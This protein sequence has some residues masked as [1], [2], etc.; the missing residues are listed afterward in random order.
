MPWGRVDDQ[1]Y[2]HEKVGELDDDLRKGCIALFWL[3]I[4]WCNDRL[5]DGRVP[6]GIVRTLGADSAEADELVRVGLWERDGRGYRVHDFLDFNKSR[7]QVEADRIQ[8]TEAGRLGAKARW[9]GGAPSVSSSGSASDSS[10]EPTDEP[11]GGS[12][13]PVP[14]IPY[15]VTP[16]P[17]A[18]ARDGLTNIDDEATTFLEGVTGRSLRTAGEKQLAEFDRQIG[19]HGLARV[20]A[21]YQRIAKSLPS[22]P[23]PTARQ[24]VWGGMKVLEP[25][26]D[27]KVQEA[28]EREEDTASAWRSRVARTKV[29]THDNGLHADSPDAG[30]P[31]CGAAA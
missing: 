11:D 13:A 28:V 19:D 3:A 1:H 5:T 6:A 30:C 21:A 4:S 14:R 7:A 16:V 9:S 17:A 26:A 12:D 27:P 24:L 29:R 23:P 18:I 25:F 8:R 31:K 15:P 2:R 20:I 22:T 10:D